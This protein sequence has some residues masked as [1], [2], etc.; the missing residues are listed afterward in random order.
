M[1][2]PA[3]MTKTTAISVLTLTSF[4]FANAGATN[5]IWASFPWILRFPPNFYQLGFPLAAPHHLPCAHATTMATT[6]LFVHAYQTQ[7]L[8]IREDGSLLRGTSGQTAILR[9]KLTKNRTPS[10]LSTHCNPTSPL[11]MLFANQA[12]AWTSRL[13]RRWLSGVERLGTRWAAPAWRHG[14]WILGWMAGAA[15]RL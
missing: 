12:E 8:Y 7:D 2:E 14:R 4:L 15:V 10:R 5:Q 9:A 1:L 3:F 11:S 13:Y 6:C